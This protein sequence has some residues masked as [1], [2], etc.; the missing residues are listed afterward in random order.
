MKY[1]S[2]LGLYKASNVTFN[3]SRIEAYSYDW[4]KFVSKIN[5]YIVF[6]NY[7][8]ST[9]TCRHQ[10]KVRRLLKSLG[11]DVNITIK[12]PKG[13]QNLESAIH[14]YNSEINSLKDAIAKKGSKALKNK[15]RLAQISELTGKIEIVK[16]L[17][18]GNK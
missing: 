14:F 5:G 7:T 1:Y 10:H 18:K 6:N 12:A 17:M 2:R 3:P 8:Y 15:E 13:L 4:W 11:I 9:T 16:F